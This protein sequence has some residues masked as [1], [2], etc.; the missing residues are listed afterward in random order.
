M[1]RRSGDGPELLT[2]QEGST[3]TTDLDLA[4]L[5][6]L[7]DFTAQLD[8]EQAILEPGIH[9]PD[10]IRKLE[11]ALEAPIG[12]SPVEETAFLFILGT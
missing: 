11:L 10:I 7:G 3:F 5:H 9:H 12:D 6:G 8:M 1:S 2:F 4:G